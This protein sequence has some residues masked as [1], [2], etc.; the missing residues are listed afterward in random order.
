MSAI[1]REEA[2]AEAHRR[3][4]LPPDM[5]AAYEEASR[6]GLFARSAEQGSVGEQQPVAHAE[7]GDRAGQGLL[8]PMADRKI[9]ARV[10]EN[11]TP[12]RSFSDAWNDPERNPILR[13][14]QEKLIGTGRGL[15]DAWEGAKQIVLQ[16]GEK[17]GLVDPAKRQAWE[18]AVEEER[19]FYERNMGDSRAAMG[20]RIVG[21]A[22]PY[23]VIPGPS[24]TAS[25][26]AKIGQS[27]LAG[28][29][30]AA[31][32]YVPERESRLENAA[33][34]ALTGAGTSAALEGASRV[35]GK[36]M[37]AAH[38]K[39]ADPKAQ[40]LLSLSEKH[41]VPLSYGDI[42]GGSVVPK[43]ETAT[44]YVPLAGLGKFREAQHAKARDAARRFLDSQKPAGDDWA[45]IAQGSLKDKAEQVRLAAA[46][47]YDRLAREADKL[48]PVPSARMNDAAKAII[49]EELGKHPQYQDKA[50]IS[51]LEK[52]THDPQASFSGLR[53]IRS[54]LGDAIA[55]HY[56][57]ANGIVGAKGA[58][59]L[60]AI[61]NALEEDLEQFATNNGGRLKVF[62][63]LADGYY[64]RHVVPFKDAALAK[65]A[66]TDTP[67]EI[68][69]AFIQTG[70]RD[71]ARKFYD[72]MGTEG[73]QAIRY[74]MV[75]EAFDSASKGSDVF[76]PATFAN[77]L[78][79][80]QAASGVFF[81]GQ[82]KA[83]LDGITKLMRHAQRAG[84][85]MADPPTGQRVIPYL[86]A[87]AVAIRPG[88]A[89]GVAGSVFL[90]RQLMTKPWGKRL[91]L[92]ASKLEPGS[93]GME[94][95][96]RQI[97]RQL[98]KTAAVA[99]T[100]PDRQGETQR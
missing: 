75:E 83:E 7:T 95:V 64:K 99:T 98:P 85:Y 91:L 24:V 34:G 31:A 51:A 37:N 23:A 49:A 19:Q 29:G 78:E 84:Q 82:H 46:Q 90:I 69:R 94:T 89:A 42:A 87:G 35:A 48:G 18:Q 58:R 43:L 41:D 20:G 13:A 60:Q 62:W 44:E 53:A 28:G 56:R 52:Y 11:Q 68:Y 93:K 57:G 9:T 59:H 32:Q 97:E 50:L 15:T 2:L 79:S 4:I 74:K 40:E 33:V 67:D 12:A 25:L 65:A 54:D 3:G 96:I 80:V 71:R 36:I 16:V 55:D 5:A 22:A 38:G 21:N 6:R 70:K 66:N 73:R 86:T 72:A 61:K 63:R 92:S 39:V 88:E 26:S 81:R 100:Q 30:V 8:S 1:T 76:S 47:K 17:M 77:K 10:D 27:A 45:A 14:E